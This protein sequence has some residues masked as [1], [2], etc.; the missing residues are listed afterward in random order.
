MYRAILADFI[1]EESRMRGL[2]G[3]LTAGEA[4]AGLTEIPKNRITLS[5]TGHSLG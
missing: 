5:V 4:G 1:L 3:S 2:F